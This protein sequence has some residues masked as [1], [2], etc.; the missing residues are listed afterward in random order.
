MYYPLLNTQ[1]YTE[2][3]YKPSTP[4]TKSQNSL[5]EY[6]VWPKHILEYTKLKFKS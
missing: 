2:E 5:E 6:P 1:H 4:A 3:D